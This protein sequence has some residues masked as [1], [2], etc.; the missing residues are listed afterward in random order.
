VPNNPCSGISKVYSYLEDSLWLRI[1]AYTLG[2]RYP[3][4]GER[5]ITLYAIC[6]DRTIEYHVDPSRPQTMCHATGFTPVHLVSIE[7]NDGYVWQSSVQSTDCAGH[8]GR[9]HVAGDAPKDAGPLPLPPCAEWG[10]VR[11]GICTVLAKPAIIWQRS[12]AVQGT[13]MGETLLRS[14]VVALV[15]DTGTCHGYVQ[16]VRGRYAVVL[17]AGHC[18]ATTHHVF[19]TYADGTNGYGASWYTWPDVDLGIIMAAFSRLPNSVLDLDPSGGALS[20]DAAET[21]VMSMLTSGGR[22]PVISTGVVDPNPAGTWRAT[23]P[24]ARGT[25]GTPVFTPQGYF[26]G[27]VTGGYSTVAGSATANT[28]IVGGPTAFSL[29]R[30]AHHY[31][32]SAGPENVRP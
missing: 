4:P 3:R 29:L 25:S 15:V 27:I 30:Q 23:I 7:C 8:G 21:P 14:T 31:P 5:I 26:A 13:T 32:P 19:I 17:T 20:P 22:E 11:D 1:Q 6:D 12:P 28:V 10:P 2:P 24:I 18:L 9:F 16:D